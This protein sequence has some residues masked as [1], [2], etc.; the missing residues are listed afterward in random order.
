MSANASLAAKPSLTLKRHLNA[1]PE[2]VYDAWTDPE[3]IVKWFG[4]D[5][6][7]VRHAETDVR[8][9]GRYAVCF[10]TEDGEEHNVSGIYRD[11]IPGEKLAFTWAWRT[12]PERESF[13]TVLITPDGDG[14]LLTLIHEQF[15]DEEARDRHREGW[16]GCLD[17]LERFV[18]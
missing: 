4:P 5:S 18:A 17:K 11:V 1:P 15:F 6:G 16:T 7:E 3:K 9:G 14:T 12:M 2:K 10:F 13:L 8:V